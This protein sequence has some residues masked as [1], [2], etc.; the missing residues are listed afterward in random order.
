[1]LKN[2]RFKKNRIYVFD[3]K[4]GKNFV[5]NVRNVECESRFYDFEFEG[6]SF[7][8]EPYLSEI[9]SAAKPHFD[10]ILESDS[11]LALSPEARAGLCIFFSIQFSRTLV[12]R[13]RWREIPELLGEKPK[14]M[15]DNEEQLENVSEY[16]R[17]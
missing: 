6:E 5:T 17:S 10:A 13:E 12:F 4:L 9:E 15:V 8:L 3:K 11:L 1:M 16:I 7:T 14:A 2:F